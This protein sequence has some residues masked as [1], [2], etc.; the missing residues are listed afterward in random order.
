MNHKPN[1]IESFRKLIGKDI[2]KSENNF[3]DFEQTK[4]NSIVRSS[5]YGLVKITPNAI[6]LENLIRIIK[7]SDKRNY[8]YREI[9]NM[10]GGYDVDHKYLNLFMTKLSERIITDQD[11]INVIELLISNNVI[12]DSTHSFDWLN[13]LLK[14]TNTNIRVIV[15][16]D[17]YDIVVL[18]S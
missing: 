1:D 13:N 17:K 12:N 16:I 8:L 10:F 11:L 2:R 5:E 4:K 6:A 7:I 15:Y 9:A 3:G 14:Y 18:K